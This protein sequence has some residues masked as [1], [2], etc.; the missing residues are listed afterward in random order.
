MESRIVNYAPGKF[1]L[2]LMYLY[3]F[4]KGIKITGNLTNQWRFAIIKTV[5]P[6]CVARAN[7]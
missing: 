3:D 5:I 1:A 7:Q 6:L 2:I 4:G